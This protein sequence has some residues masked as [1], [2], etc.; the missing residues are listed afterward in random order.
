M[1]RCNIKIA[2]KKYLQTNTI[3]NEIEYRRKRA[4]AKREIRKNKANP[5]KNLY[6]T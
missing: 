4:N 6:H 2:F 5:W 3:D 1:G